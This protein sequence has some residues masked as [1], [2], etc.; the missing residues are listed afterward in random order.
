[1]NCTGADYIATYYNIG[2]GNVEFGAGNGNG[3]FNSAG[4]EEYF[5]EDRVIDVLKSCASLSSAEIK[6]RLIDDVSQFCNGQFQ[7]D[8]TFILF[9]FVG[10][11]LPDPEIKSDIMKSENLAG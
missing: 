6:T 9:K 1:M 10:V 3:N 7:D 11:T 8:I 2:S 5:G 4:K